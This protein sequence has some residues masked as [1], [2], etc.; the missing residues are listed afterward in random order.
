M[1]PNNIAGAA[2]S[3]ALQ[4]PAGQTI[5]KIIT[6]SNALIADLTAGSITAQNI[7]TNT[8]QAQQVKHW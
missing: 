2:L 5:N 7:Q 4:T 6:A 3:F 1:T 8:L